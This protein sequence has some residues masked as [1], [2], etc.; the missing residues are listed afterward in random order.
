MQHKQNYRSENYNKFIH[1]SEKNISRLSSYNFLKWFSKKKKSKC[2]VQKHNI[3]L[4][5]FCESLVKTNFF[6]VVSS[7][8]IEDCN[9]FIPIA[10]MIFK[11]KKWLIT[12]K[13]PLRNC[14]EKCRYLDFY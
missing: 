7:E 1:L 10:E 12:D 8:R 9:K 6:K 13:K 3:Q 14:A 11:D 2:Q 4:K 5:E